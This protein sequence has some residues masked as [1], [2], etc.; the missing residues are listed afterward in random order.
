MVYVGVRKVGLKNLK[1]VGSLECS[2]HPHELVAA[3]SAH[4]SFAFWMGSQK[5]QSIVTSL[6]NWQNGTR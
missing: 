2:A 3:L 4:S 6:V 1:I 5:S